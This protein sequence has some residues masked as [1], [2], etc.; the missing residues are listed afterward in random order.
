M[1]ENKITADTLWEFIES[2]RRV[3]GRVPKLRE[4]VEHFDG[5]LLNVLL[6]FAELPPARA[7][8]IRQAVSEQSQAEHDARKR[9]QQLAVNAW[10]NQP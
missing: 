1:S 3:N 2:S 10:N 6:C 9:K 8:A 5:K 7:N 4:C